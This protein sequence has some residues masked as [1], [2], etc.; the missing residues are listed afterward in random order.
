MKVVA[1]VSSFAFGNASLRV[2]VQRPLHVAL[3][4]SAPHEKWMYIIWYLTCYLQFKPLF[5]NDA[6]T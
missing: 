5:T 1:Y 6:V 2:L 3:Y 4:S